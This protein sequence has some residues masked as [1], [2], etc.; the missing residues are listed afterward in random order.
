MAMI[1]DGTSNTYLVGEKYVV[2]NY[3]ATGQDSGDAETYYNG[4]D[5]DNQRTGWSQPMQDTPD[6]YPG[7]YGSIAMFGSAHDSGI[8]MAF[9]DGSVHQISYTI[10]SHIPGAPRPGNGGGYVY[11]QP[12]SA[13]DPPGVHQRL[14]NRQDGWP[15]DSSSF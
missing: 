10:D 13:S 6:Y 5:D 3:Y 2:P 7:T 9:C 15:V 1:S 11:G 4:D 8:N 14:A 12:Q